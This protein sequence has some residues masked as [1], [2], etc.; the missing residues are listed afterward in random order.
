MSETTDLAQYIRNLRIERE[1]RLFDVAK[2]TDIDTTMVSKIERGDRLPTS[3]HVKRIAKFYN[4]SEEAM[5]I[6]LTAEKI[7]KEYGLNEMTLNAVRL[8]EEQATPY[9]KQKN[10]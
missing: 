9:I 3:E 4:V 10:K 2:G 8:V 5:M 1:L 7:I 6:Q